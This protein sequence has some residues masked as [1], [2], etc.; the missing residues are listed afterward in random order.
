MYHRVFLTVYF[1]RFKPPLIYSKPGTP[2]ALL[3]HHRAQH[4]QGS[5]DSRQIIHHTKRLHPEVD[6]EYSESNPFVL[7]C[8]SLEPLF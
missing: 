5:L 7:K 2:F 1:A 3:T 4:K 6:D 8:G